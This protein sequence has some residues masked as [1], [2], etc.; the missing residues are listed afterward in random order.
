VFWDKYQIHLQSNKAMDV[1]AAYKVRRKE[2]ERR[3]TKRKEEERRGTKRNGQ[4]YMWPHIQY[5]V[6]LTSYG[7]NGSMCE[8]YDGRMVSYGVEVVRWPRHH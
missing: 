1:L 7:N 4:G 6:Y 2:E 5:T 8:T 3:G